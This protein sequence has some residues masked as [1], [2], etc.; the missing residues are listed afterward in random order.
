MPDEIVLDRTKFFPPYKVILHNDDY[1]EM[2]YVITALMNS[3]TSLSA[4]EAKRIM[5][6][7][8]VTGKAVVIVCPRET[9]E[10]YQERLLSYRLTVTIEPD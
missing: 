4:E 2:G 3:V 8:H 10:F 9:A 6:T 1:H 5:F 7:A